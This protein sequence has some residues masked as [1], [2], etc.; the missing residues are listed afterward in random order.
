MRLAFDSFQTSFSQS[1][2]NSQFKD[3]FRAQA[4]YEHRWSTWAWRAGYAWYPSPAPDM[5]GDLN[6]LDSDR[7]TLHAG[8]GKNWDKPFDFLDGQ[9][10]VDL[11]AFAQY[12]VPKDITKSNSN[13]VGYPGYKVGGW[14]YGYGVTL[15]S[16]L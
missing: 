8:L 13:S 3:I 5:S 15:T 14:V 11:A 6:F 1:L 9:I 2:P 10:K 12:L 7:H 4:G 16:E